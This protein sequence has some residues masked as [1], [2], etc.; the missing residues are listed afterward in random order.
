M[1]TVLHRALPREPLLGVVDSSTDESRM[2]IFASSDVDPGAYYVFDRQA[3]GCR[4]FSRRA[5]NLKAQSWPRCSQSP[6]RLR[7]AC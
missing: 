6:I 5:R 2:L 7:T 3:G 1:L 4:P